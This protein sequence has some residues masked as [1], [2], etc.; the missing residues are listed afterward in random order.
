MCGLPEGLL[1]HT[2]PPLGPP[3]PPARLLAAYRA[4]PYR[5]VPYRAP[6]RTHHAVRVHAVHTRRPCRLPALPPLALPA[7]KGKG[8]RQPRMTA[9]T[10]G[11]RAGAESGRGVTIMATWPASSTS[12]ASIYETFRTIGSFGK[13]LKHFSLSNF[14]SGLCIPSLLVLGKPSTVLYDP[15]IY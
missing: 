8:Q 2:H 6:P 4:V 3:G 5:A 1:Y 7:R 12:L 10:L 15:G 14:L 9:S 11:G 13:E